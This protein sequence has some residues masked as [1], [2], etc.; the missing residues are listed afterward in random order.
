[1]SVFPRFALPAIFALVGFAPSPG[2]AQMV[3]DR[4]ALFLSDTPVS[5]RYASKES[6]RSAEAATYRQQIQT[7]QRVLRDALA[8][9]NIQVTG[10][11]VSVMNAVF[12]ATTPDRVNEIKALPGVI[13][14]VRMRRG[15]R[16][17][18]DATRLMN[19]PAAWN[20][21]GGM[22]KAGEGVK[23]AILDTGI[24]QSHPAFQDNSLPVPAGY[25]ICSDSDCDFTNHKVIVA[26]SYVR[27]IAAANGPSTS[28]PDDYSARDRD[29]HGTAVASAAAANVNTGTVTF[30]GM[31]PKAYLG[32]YKVYG[33]P[34]VNDFP[35]EDI[36]IQAIED[37]LNDGMD[38]ANFSSG[39]PALSGPLDTGAVCGN[40]DG[41]ACD[42]LA[43]AFENAA[44]GGLVITVSAGN[45][46]GTGAL[47]PTFA[48][49]GSPAN[50]PSVITVGATT[51]AHVFETTVSIPRAPSNLQNIPGKFGD[52]FS[53]FG[54]VTARLIDV[55]QL[56]NDGFACSALPADSLT[57]AIALIERG[58]ASNPCTFLEKTTN[59]QNAG[60]IAVIFYMEDSSTPIYPGGIGS[61][62]SG[63]TVM[64]S[65]SDGVAVKSYVDAHKGS[66][67]TIDPA[68]LEQAVSSFN[69]LASYSSLGPNIGDSAV[70]PEI[71][72]TGGD[73][74]TE[75][76]NSNLFSS[77]EIYLAAENYDQNGELYSST[78]Y[79]AAD[80]TSFS[81]PITAG[82]AALVKQH[83]PAFTAAQIKSALVNSAAQDVTAD[84][85]GNA[86]NVQWVGAGRLD[87]GAAVNAT[88][89][90]DP[91]TISFGV[92]TSGSLPSN[93]QIHITN[94]GSSSVNLALAIQQ[95]TS[96]S[97]TNLA[98]DKQGLTL[99]PGATSSVN[100]TLSGS[101]P[102]SG[103]YDGAVTLKGS[104]VSSRVPYQFLVGSGVGANLIAQ[105][106]TFLDGEVN[107]DLGF[108]TMKVIDGSGVAVPNASVTF[109]VNPQG[110]VTLSSIDGA[111]A[112]SPSTSS[113]TL[114]CPTDNYGDAF[115]DV[116]LGSQPG[117]PVIRARA[118]GSTVT[119]NVN[120]RQQPT[121]TSKGVVN[122]ASFTSPIA[123][124]S[125]VTIFGSAL[126][127]PGNTMR[128]TTSILPLALDAVTVSFDVPSANLSVP[129]YMYFVSPGQV[130]IQV[131]WE[132][133]GQPS[134]KVK[135][136]VNE[137]SW[138]NVVTVP[139]ADYTPAFFEGNGM[140]AAVDTNGK[141]IKASNPAVTGKAI[142]LF[143]NGLGPVTHQPASGS[144]A[145]SSPSLAET[146]SKPV[147]MIGG[148]QATVSFSGLAPGFSGLY[149][150]NVTV[151][152]N[153]TAGSYPITLSI[154]G[155]TSPTAQLP[156]R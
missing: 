71:V 138:G 84:D 11:T 88:V 30:N 90:A 40:P 8:Q 98:L 75:P 69:Q 108:I 136:T 76:G 42:P 79:A 129:G 92:L 154:G 31:A 37:A 50:A 12:V 142:Q 48:T 140:V 105:A 14:V 15:K 16:T 21:L 5:S 41:V 114:T 94:T 87:A 49:V 28:M 116:A 112:C 150:V 34:G 1:M 23:I 126:S 60:A 55:S 81:S 101:M 117:Q 54:A 107:Q 19:A 139:L 93:R 133:Q 63:L 43:Q 147:V 25:P 111:P 29:G 53:P 95:N 145:P 125:Y 134:A 113:S 143:A 123:P 47:S 127:D 26:R 6:A 97:G 100:V 22:S 38:I 2:F 85:Q 17:M 135:V 66:S 146:T 32:S 102:Q 153:L 13:G 46:N 83:H 82:A 130:N 151:P 59:A 137:T 122:A 65:H 58:P 4:Y 118:A 152:S 72:A 124:G 18:N 103:F 7:R 67:A 121:I 56:G 149:Q 70:K 39:L 110:S 141:V 91:T 77:P 106:G 115:V 64:I 74:V 128:A 96:A 45:E 10:S 144:P 78:R 62:F 57:G 132:L 35:P 52:S 9:R 36:F 44:K 80:G 24:D 99:S 33:S 120:I 109:S 27:Q 68:G 89:F 86:V 131:P 104:G 148:Q 156:V 51:N 119:T 73:Q 3:S 61:D 155:V 20:V